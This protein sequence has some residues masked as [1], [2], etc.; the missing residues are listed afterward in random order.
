VDDLVLETRAQNDLT[1]T[2]GPVMMTP[3]IGADYW[4]WRVRVG[5]GQA[6]I[7]F[8]K[9]MTIGIGFAVEDDW[10]TNLPY[11]SDA[12]DI[13]RHIKHNKGDDSISDAECIAAIRLIQAAA[14][15]F[16]AESTS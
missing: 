5:P 7:G 14:A 15:A 13:Y 3:P 10:N 6:V 1:P 4:A 16:K 11:T 12:E 8:P 9:F 2:A